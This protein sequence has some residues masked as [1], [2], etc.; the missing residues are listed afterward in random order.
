M[1]LYPVYER[2][3]SDLAAAVDSANASPEVRRPVRLWDFSGYNSITTEDVPDHGDGTVRMDWYWDSAHYTPA[4]GE[5]VLARMIGDVVSV[6]RDFG[7]RLNTK[8]IPNL[9][10]Q[11]QRLRTRYSTLHPEEIADVK[12]LVRATAE[13]RRRLIQQYDATL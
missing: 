10:A 2:W 6:P 5:L 7:E 1:G 3:L 13:L 11:E 9:F 12:H 8:T 4:A